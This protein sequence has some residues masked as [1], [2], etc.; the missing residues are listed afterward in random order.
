MLAGYATAFPVGSVLEF[1][2]GLPSEAPSGNLIGEVVLPENPFILGDGQVSLNGEWRGKGLLDGR[3]SSYRL[4]SPDGQFIEH[5]TVTVA[6]GGGG[7]TLKDIRVYKNQ[8]LVVEDF[9][10]SL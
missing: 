10:R 2:D 3:A 9:T 7:A 4:I 8:E 5:G 6:D 1:R